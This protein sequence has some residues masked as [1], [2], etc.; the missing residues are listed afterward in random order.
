MGQSLLIASS[1]AQGLFI[2]LFKF[3]AVSLYSYEP[4]LTTNN[5]CVI[6]FHPRIIYIYVYPCEVKT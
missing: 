1:L 4:F 6:L 5:C 3:S 2:I